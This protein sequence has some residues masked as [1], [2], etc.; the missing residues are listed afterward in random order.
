[1]SDC[2]YCGK[3]IM[4]KSFEPVV[5]GVP[6]GVFCSLA[7]TQAAVDSVVSLLSEITG[8]QIIVMPVAQAKYDPAEMN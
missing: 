1:M 7:C 5:S 6:I 8:E 3:P 4:H 2:N